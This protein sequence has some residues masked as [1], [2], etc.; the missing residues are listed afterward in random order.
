MIRACP[1]CAQKNRIPAARLHQ[2]GK[3]G[4][5]KEAIP[6]V[7][8][9]LDVDTAAFDDITAHAGVPVLVD[10]WAPWCGPC[11]M[12]APTVT[13]IAGAASGRALVLKVD[14]DKHPALSKRFGIRGIPHFILFKAGKPV[15]QH[16]G[17]VGADL[18]RKWL[19]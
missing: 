9:P 1:Q 17:L 15:F 11:R 2:N 5:C 6:K 10:F 18:L 16:S 4:S 7:S 8:A 14:T 19:S 12:A 13:K 3:C